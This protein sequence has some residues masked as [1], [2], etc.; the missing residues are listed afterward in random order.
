MSTFNE[1]GTVIV[2]WDFSNGKNSGILLVGKQRPD[3]AP[4]IINALESEE[5]HKLM[6]KLTVRNYGKG[7]VVG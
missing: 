5:A 7:P 1:S 6:K 4:E 3:A 2:S